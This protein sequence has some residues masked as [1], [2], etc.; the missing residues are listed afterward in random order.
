MKLKYSKYPR[1]FDLNIQLKKT[2]NWW[3]SKIVNYCTFFYF[4]F[5]IKEI[6]GSV[7]HP[8][9][10]FPSHTFMNHDVKKWWA[11]I[12]V[13]FFSW[14]LEASF[15]ASLDEERE[16]VLLHNLIWGVFQKNFSMKNHKLLRRF[17]TFSVPKKSF[18][19]AYCTK[20]VYGSRK[21]LNDKIIFFPLSDFILKR[22]QI[23]FLRISIASFV[24]FS[25]E[26]LIA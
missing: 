22:L 11:I 4:S 8:N 16:L 6:L 13:P 19:L 17:L 5:E 14:E 25:C 7:S 18:S 21:S 20:I 26:T 24:A 1:A 12:V 23:F 3:L 10:I 2:W 9:S 15:L